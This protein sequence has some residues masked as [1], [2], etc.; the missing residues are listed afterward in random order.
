ME[1]FIGLDVHASSTT[2]GVV[3]PTGRRLQSQVVATS[4]PALIERSRGHKNTHRIAWAQLLKR[5]L[6]IDVQ[7]CPRCGGPMR[8]VQL[9]KDKPII[10]K[11]LT[12][13][14]LPTNPPPVAAARPPPQAELDWS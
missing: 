3:G 9:V 4:A 14:N 7:T 10:D 13:L 5:T 12:H 11:I 2:I 6:D 1:R 8:L